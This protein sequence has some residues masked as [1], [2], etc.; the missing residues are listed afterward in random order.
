[1]AELRHAKVILE[2]LPLLHC[3]A[4]EHTVDSNSQWVEMRDPALL[5]STV[6]PKVSGTLTVQIPRGPQEF[7][8]A[9]K[10]EEGRALLLQ[11]V[12]GD[13]IRSAQIRIAQVRRSD[14][15]AADRT[16]TITYD[17]YLVRRT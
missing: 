1:M 12:D 13:G 7:E 2:G 10:L 6:P 11:W 3:T 9:N 15:F 8:Y 5:R 4:A 16:C 17:G 14:N